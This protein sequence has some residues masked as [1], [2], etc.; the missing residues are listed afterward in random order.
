MYLLY[1]DES[2]NESEPSDRYFVLGGA[3]I[4]ERVTYHISNTFDRI[5]LKHFP[6]LEPIEFHA[7]QIR[8]GKGFWRKV[9]PAKRDAVLQDIEGAISRS[10]APGVVLF[11]AAIEKSAQLYGEQ[12]VEYATEQICNRFDLFL[13]RRRKESKDMQRG[14]LIFSKGRF[15]KRAGVWVRNF[16]KLGTQWGSLKNLCDIPYFASTK[17]SRM[18]QLADFVAHAVYL[19]YERGDDTLLKPLLARFDQKDGVLHGLA[20]FRTDATSTCNCPACSSRNRN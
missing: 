6:G 4:F 16:R 9:A 13:M 2:G 1:L 20:H 17:E 5:Q 10:N 14:L 15:D 7:T 8:G 3:A 11:A 19:A 18:L 12:A